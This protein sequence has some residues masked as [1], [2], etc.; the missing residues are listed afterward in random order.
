MKP[1]SALLLIVSWAGLGQAQADTHP[2]TLQQLRA[3]VEAFTRQDVQRDRARLTAFSEDQQQQQQLL[4]RLRAEVAA[5][6]QRQ[7]QLQQTYSDNQARLHAL[8]QQL[9]EQSGQVAEVFAVVRQHGKELRPQLAESAVTAQYPQRLSLLDFTDSSRLPDVSAIEGL[10]YLLE[11]EISASAQISSFSGSWVGSDGQRQQGDLWRLG[12]WQVL[13]AQGQYLG[14]DPKQQQ[15]LQWARQPDSAAPWLAQQQPALWLD[16]SRGQVLELLQR[17]PSLLERIAQGGL[18]GYVILAL[19]AI[20][21]LVA[22][23]RVIMLLR[24]SWQVRRQLKSKQWRLDNPLGRVLAHVGEARLQAEE[25]EVRVDEAILRELPRLERGIALLKLLAAVAPL[26]GLLGTVTGMIG[27]FQSITLFGTSDPRLMAG[28]ISQALVT[29]VQ[30]LV[31]AIPLLFCHSLVQGRSRRLL[32]VLQE[33]SLS[34]LAQRWEQQGQQE[35]PRH[36]A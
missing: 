19:G 23:V 29:T 30:G 2:V 13:T 24:T 33:K 20:G 18:V 17:Q 8:R 6:D 21:M 27:T 11:Q 4:E 12:N 10:W 15:L 22:L 1:W 26:L 7:Q 36:A 16:P 32:Q 25:L 5:Q 14:Y 31:V 28:G 35:R 34:A 3:E 9:Q